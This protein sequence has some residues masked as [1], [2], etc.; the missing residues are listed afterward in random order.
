MY[1]SGELARAISAVGNSF[2]KETQPATFVRPDAGMRG[3]G[4]SKTRSVRFVIRCF[5][6][7]ILSRRPVLMS[8]LTRASA[9]VTG[10]RIA[11]S[12]EGNCVRTFTLRLNSVQ[13]LVLRS[14]IEMVAGSAMMEQRRR[15]Q[16]GTREL[17]LMG[18][19]FLNIVMSWGKC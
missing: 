3:L 4:E 8:A 14:L 7:R 6:Q 11:S 13:G 16:V 1:V 12:A 17:R 10:E 5:A 18:A 15:T 2:Q 19:G 9:L